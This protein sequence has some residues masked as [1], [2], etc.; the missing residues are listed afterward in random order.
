[1]QL[2]NDVAEVAVYGVPAETWGEHVK[3][4][5]VLVPGSKLTPEDIRQYCRNNMPH[6]RV[7]REIEI[8]PSLPKNPS[9]K[10]LVNELKKRSA[11]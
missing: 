11:K 10:V 8:L 5:L 3:A 9:G 4:S 6:F 7:P 2:T 1:M